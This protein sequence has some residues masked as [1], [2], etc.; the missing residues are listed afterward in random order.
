M[1]IYKSMFKNRKFLIG[2][3]IIMLLLLSS[4]LYE[5]IFSAF[6][7]TTL[8]LYENDELIGKAPFSPLETP[9]FG[10]DRAGTPLW[11]YVVQGAKFT[12]V[13]AIAISVLQVIMSTL[14]VSTSFNVL[15]KSVFLIEKIGETMIYVPTIAIAFILLFPI[16]FAIDPT[17]E[18]LKYITIQILLI[19]IIG[20]P[21]LVNNLT[22]EV[23][24]VLNKE[25]VLAAK[26]LGTT[27]WDLYKKHVL[28][29]LNPY[30]IFLCLQKTIQVL[31]LFVQ[32]GLLGIFLGGEI[33]MEL[34]PDEITYMSLSNEWAGN[35]G[36]AYKEL[37]LAPW[38]IAVPLVAY[39]VTIY[40]LNLMSNGLQESLLQVEKSNPLQKLKE[41]N[42]DKQEKHAQFSKEQF[43][44]VKKTY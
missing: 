30:L 34:S 35:I 31:T 15:K 24:K 43:K 13:L 10:T 8:V 7:D 41:S 23:Q 39:T 16:T 44:F 33:A 6:D 21:E 14:I 18:F 9:P 27:G 5:P 37:L 2:F 22:K 26:T 4:F 38:I 17:Q 20:M 25:Y 42:D 40:S 11:I 36:K 19:I 29:T 28:K 1:P 32:L 3:S 12:I